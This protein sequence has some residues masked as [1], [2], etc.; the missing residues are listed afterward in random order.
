VVVTT[1]AGEVALLEPE[2][3]L[4]T[5]VAGG[6]IAAATLPGAASSCWT[7]HWTT[8]CAPRVCA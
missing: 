7:S 8:R 2:Y 5:V 4:R 6:D 3:D 1:P